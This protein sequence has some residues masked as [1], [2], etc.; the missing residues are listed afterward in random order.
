MSTTDYLESCRDWGLKSQ[1][2]AR[3]KAA[4][5]L[6]QTELEV[7]QS[8]DSFNQRHELFPAANG[9]IDLKTGDLLEHSRDLGFTWVSRIEYK[10]NAR[11]P[12]WEEFL[13]S[14]FE[15]DEERIGFVQRVVGYWLTGLNTEHAIFILIGRGRNGKTT[16]IKPIQDILS[17][18]ATQMPIQ[19]FL[20]DRSTGAAPRPDIIRMRDKR[21]VVSSEVNQQQTV[22]S[23]LLKGLSGGDRYIG[24]T[25]YAAAYEEFTPTFK[26]C[27]LVNDYPLVSEGD[28]ALF[29]RLYPVPFNRVF[30][31]NEQDKTLGGRLSK[32]LEGILAWAVKGAQQWFGQGLNPP[33]SIL[34]AR[35]A[36]RREMSPVAS[37]LE[38]R[39]VQ[40][41]FE[42]AAGDLF[43]AYLRWAVE[44]SLN[45]ISQNAFG[46]TL[47]RMGFRSEK[48]GTKRWRGLKLCNH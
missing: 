38:E 27:L 17:A 48:K 22:D 47:T 24:R 42:T 18:A 46:R 4:V 3:L 28:E 23:A 20:L 6:A 15:G 19:S 8:Y 11:C 1:S 12:T 31:S 35:D 2:S 37:F 16:F 30:A 21:L 10:S 29:S 14:V 9:V 32:E 33:K 36:Y 41:S 25:L 7:I 40:G 5:E 26:L 43:N 34:N 45:P 13:G 39:C 44:E